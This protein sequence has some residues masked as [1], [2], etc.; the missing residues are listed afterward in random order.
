MSNV[1]KALSKQETWWERW[2][3]GELQGRGSRRTAFL[4][5]IWLRFY[6]V[7]ELVSGWSVAQLF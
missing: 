2:Q 4:W 3:G 6:V 5:A 7:T 1:W